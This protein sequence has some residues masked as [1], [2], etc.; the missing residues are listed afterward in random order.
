ML[1]D[2]VA[3]YKVRFSGAGRTQDHDAPKRVDNAD[4]TAAHL[5]F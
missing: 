3:D 4:S 1:G 5:A 2:H